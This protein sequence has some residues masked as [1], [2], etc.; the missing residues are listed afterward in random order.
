MVCFTVLAVSA[1]SVEEDKSTE[2]D[3]SELVEVVGSDQ[4]TE[5]WKGRY[6]GAYRP[7]V[8]YYPYGYTSYGR[9]YGSGY[10]KHWRGRRSA[11]VSD[12]ED[13]QAEADSRW[14]YYRGYPYYSR[15]YS[16]YYRPHYYSRRYPSYSH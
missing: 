9:H 7:Y 1:A 15:P 2:V 10:K 11:V 14:G 13:Q 6:Y 8:H 4:D 12:D 16:S 5:E 3:S